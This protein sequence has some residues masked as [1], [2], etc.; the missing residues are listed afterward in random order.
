MYFAES[1]FF[2]IFRTQVSRQRREGATIL[3]QV[4]FGGVNFSL[5]RNTR[6]VK[7]YGTATAV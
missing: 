2:A 6:G 5:E 3:K 1:H 7:F 4:P